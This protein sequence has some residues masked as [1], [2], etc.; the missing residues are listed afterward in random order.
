VAIPL[1]ERG[2]PVS[3]IELSPAMA[4]RLRRKTTDVPVVVGDMAATTVPG[5][6]T[7]VYC[8]WNSL[9]NLRTQAEQVACFEN[10]ARH[11]E[12]GG[13][14]V[15]ELTVPPL[16]RLPPGQSAV[17]FHVGARHVGFDTLDTVTQQGTSHHYERHPD[18][19][20][21][22]EVSNF[23]YAWPAECDLMAQLAGLELERR[24]ADWH[25]TP[26]TA[27]SENHVSVW[28]KPA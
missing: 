11:L 18:G 23:R 15:V 5:R 4:D 13:R 22:Y 17:P 19:T 6:F 25:G 12:P 1:L 14:F 28:R 16:R 24:V 3:G 10:A 7:L 2:I 27:D 9:G 8:V 21:S 26:F 20:V